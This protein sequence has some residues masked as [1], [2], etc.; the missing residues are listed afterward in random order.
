[1]GFGEPERSP[2]GA[3]EH[4]LTSPRASRK[5]PEP[6]HWPARSANYAMPFTRAFAFVAQTV[7]VSAE[8]D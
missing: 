7:P 1:M 2:T 8:H 4:S 5:E 3:R 6:E